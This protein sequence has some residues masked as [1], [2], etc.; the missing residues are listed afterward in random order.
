M[1]RYCGL[2]LMSGDFAPLETN[3][4]FQQRLFDR[5]FESSTCFSKAQKGPYQSISAAFVFNWSHF[6][7]ELL[8]STWC[9]HRFFS[10]LKS[11]AH[12]IECC[13]GLELR[14]EC[15]LGFMFVISRF[16]HCEVNQWQV[17]TKHC[18]CLWSTLTHCVER[19]THFLFRI[20]VC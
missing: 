13:S 18:Q 10:F 8:P 2:I 7:G 5:P 6:Q 12:R 20:S 17:K 19:F 1:C 3:I 4:I 15:M 14:H 16:H 9:P 11:S